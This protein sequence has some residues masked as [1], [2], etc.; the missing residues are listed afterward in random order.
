M[1]RKLEAAWFM[2]AGALSLA[3]IIRFF[4]QN[5]FWD[6]DEIEP[7]LILLGRTFALALVALRGGVRRE[8]VGLGCIVSYWIFTNLPIPALSALYLFVIAYALGRGLVLM[9]RAERRPLAENAMI[10]LGLMAIV[11]PPLDEAVPHFRVIKATLWLL[12]LLFAK[13]FLTPTRGWW[14]APVQGWRPLLSDA[15]VASG[16]TYFAAFCNLPDVTFDSQLMHL[17]IPFRMNALGGAFLDPLREYW[18]FAPQGVDHLYAVATWGFDLYAPKM[19]NFLSLLMTAD[20]CRRWLAPRRSSA[21][22]SLFC[23]ACPVLLQQVTQSLVDLIWGEFILVALLAITRLRREIDASAQSYYAALTGLFGAAGCASKIASAPYLVA[24]VPCAWPWVRALNRRGWILL[25][26]SSV[27][28]LWWLWAGYRTTGNPLFPL[29]NDIFRSPY[30]SPSRLADLRWVEKVSWRTLYDL[31][32]EPNRFGE[33]DP[34][35][36]SL[37]FTFLLPVVFPVVYGAFAWSRPSRIFVVPLSLLFAGGLFMLELQPY[38]RYVM[39]TVLGLWIIGYMVLTRP[40]VGTYYLWATRAL[41]GLATIAFIGSQGWFARLVTKSKSERH[42]ARFVARELPHLA[43]FKYVNSSP[44][45]QTIFIIPKDFSAVAGLT[46]SAFQNNVYSE[47]RRVEFEAVRSSQ[48]LAD[49]GR[50]H[51]TRYFIVRHDE[52]GPLL[53][54]GGCRLDFASPTLDLF[55]CDF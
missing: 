8:L 36:F 24:M 14:R 11:L 38:Y 47:N 37:S 6:V 54:G 1:P 16:L 7:T 46:K 41:M 33:V 19:I 3:M 29:Y 53:K 15:A 31:S 32:V 42:R 34:G 55:K 50:R 9:I 48:D 12:P 28:S 21:T 49:F 20:I 13:D 39:P 45:I 4:D 51:D 23:L 27:L 10:G 40:T 17:N 30:F 18:A 35:V 2:L 26:L 25:A 52:P 5:H 44:D 43:L 22:L